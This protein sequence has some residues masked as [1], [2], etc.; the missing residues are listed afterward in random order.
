MVLV[1]TLIEISRNFDV[2]AYVGLLYT[3]FIFLK[4]FYMSLPSKTVKKRRIINKIKVFI[5]IQ[6]GAN[7]LNSNYI[8]FH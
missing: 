8:F 3:I 6:I 1:Y 5:I 4:K 7:V 2:G